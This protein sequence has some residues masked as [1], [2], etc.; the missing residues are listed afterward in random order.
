MLMDSI[1]YVLLVLLICLGVYFLIR[2]VC[3]PIKKS[4]ALL[5]VF[6]VIASCG[7]VLLIYKLSKG[8]YSSKNSY[9]ST[10]YDYPIYEEKPKN[11][12]E[13][14]VSSSF[15]DAF[16]NTTY[17][18]EVG[19]IVAKGITNGSNDTIIRDNNGE[20][21]ATSINLGNGKTT[22]KDK[23][24]NIVNSLTN[25]WGDE[26]FDD[27]KIAKNDSFGNKRF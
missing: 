18:D 21:V 20:V 22:Y 5:L 10:N 1:I 15:T 3:Y 19:N 27:G 12:K 14:K 25:Q 24:G 7:I 8:G 13:S 11:K 6:P 16:G 17:Y 26:T 9:N 2:K 4:T 23:D